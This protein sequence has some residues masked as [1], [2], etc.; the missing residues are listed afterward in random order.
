MLYIEKARLVVSSE[1]L[2]V[3]NSKKDRLHCDC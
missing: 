1:T 3:S 2:K